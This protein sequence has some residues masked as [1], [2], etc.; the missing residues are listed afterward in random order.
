MSTTLS[1]PHEDNNE[2]LPFY[3]NIVKDKPYVYDYHI[4]PHDAKQTNVATGKSSLEVMNRLGLKTRIAP[5]LGILEGINAVKMMLPSCYFDSIRCEKGL[6]ALRNYRS[7]FNERLGTYLEKPRH[8]EHSHAS[9]AFR[10]LAVSLRPSRS[11]GQ[12]LAMTTKRNKY[13]HTQN[14]D[15]FK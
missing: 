3:I 10:Y 14:Y 13:N 4:L 12:I 6:I 11:P 1:I 2:A 5:K 7:D 15:P 8:D 9:D